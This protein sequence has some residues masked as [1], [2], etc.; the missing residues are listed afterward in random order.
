MRGKVRGYKPSL[1]GK[2]HYTRFQTEYPRFSLSAEAK[3]EGAPLASSVN[4]PAFDVSLAHEIS[5]QFG[6]HDA[7]NPDE[8]KKV[9]LQDTRTSR[10]LGALSLSPG[11]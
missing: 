4:V 11:H 2:E 9:D 10:G 1:D 8:D 7:D 3:A 6:D 5:L